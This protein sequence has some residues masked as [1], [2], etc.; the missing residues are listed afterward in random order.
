MKVRKIFVLLLVIALFSGSAVYADSVVSKLRVWLDGKEVEDMGVN[1]D[2]K[3]YLSARSVSDK[4][5]AV[6]LWDDSGKRVTIYKPNVH[7]LMMQDS[8]VV[9]SA[10]GKG[11]YTFRVFAMVDNL[12]F[13]ISAFK[14][15]MTNPYDEDTWLD[16]RDSNSKDFPKIGSDEFWINSKEI[17]YNFESAGKY[18]LRFWMKPAGE[19]SFQV[20]SEKVIKRG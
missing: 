7:M 11:K 9:G 1:V 2:G 16:G 8:L 15:T 10:A 12:K 17:T 4:F 19:S 18:I 5:N 20:V 3:T 14:I 13:D 6:L